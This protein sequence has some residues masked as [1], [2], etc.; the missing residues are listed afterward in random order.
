MDL[1]ADINLAT[2]TVSLPLYIYVYIST[3]HK[4]RYTASVYNLCIMMPGLIMYTLVNILHL[5][6]LG[7]VMELDLFLWGRDVLGIHRPLPP[8]GTTVVVAT[9]DIA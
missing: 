8:K 7:A 4:K 1:H 9:G 2:G 3:K 6:V 5:Q